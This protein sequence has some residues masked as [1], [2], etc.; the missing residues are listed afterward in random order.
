[1]VSTAVLLALLG[2]ELL[3]LVATYIGTRH[4]QALIPHLKSSLENHLKIVVVGFQ[5]YQAN[6][7]ETPSGSLRQEL[8][9]ALARVNVGHL[10]NFREHV[11]AHELDCCP[12]D[13]RQRWLDG[14][15]P[16]CLH[17]AVHRA[18]AAF[19]V[20]FDTNGGVARELRNGL[21][22]CRSLS[23]LLAIVAWG[24]HS[25]RSPGRWC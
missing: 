17:A 22:E 10:G 14:S 1:M 12:R 16:P 2:H 4:A 21:Q 8:A 18:P 11:L 19:D 23:Y 6:S 25:A 15:W 5:S 9:N 20:R 7:L 13:A 24:A 3:S